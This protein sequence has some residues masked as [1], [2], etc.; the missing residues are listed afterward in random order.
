[1]KPFHK[2]V[3]P[4]EVGYGNGWCAELDRTWSNGKYVVMARD[5]STIWGRVTHLFIRNRDNSDIPWRDKQKIKNML[6]GKEK[7]AIEVFPPEQRLVDEVGAYHLWILHDTD[8]P[9]CLKRK[10]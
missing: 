2:C 9:F 6:F 8:L 10:S 3:S 4:K 5:I 1:M 7:L